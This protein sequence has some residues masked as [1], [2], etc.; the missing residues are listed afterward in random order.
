MKQKQNNY[1]SKYLFN[2]RERAVVHSSEWG[3][4]TNFSNSEHFLLIVYMFTCELLSKYVNVW[5][6][7]LCETS[8]HEHAAYLRKN[9]FILTKSSDKNKNELSI[10][11]TFSILISFHSLP[12]SQARLCLVYTIFHFV[13]STLPKNMRLF[14][15]SIERKRNRTTNMK[16]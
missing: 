12:L 16:M 10:L 5:D 2:L 13:C 11:P 9:W 14:R 1:S 7:R 4:S 15:Y 8:T 3:K 6:L